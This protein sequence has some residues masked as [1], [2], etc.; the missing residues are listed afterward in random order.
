MAIFRSA[1]STNFSSRLC[2]LINLPFVKFNNAFPGISLKFISSNM[3]SCID[4][5]PEIQSFVSNSTEI[6]IEIFDSFS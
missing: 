2:F 3:E 5:S 1:Q 6:E 4:L